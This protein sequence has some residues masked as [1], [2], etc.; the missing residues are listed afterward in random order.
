M[1]NYK[2]AVSKDGKKYNIVFKAENEALARERVH[3][4]WYSILSLQEIFGKKEIW[5]TFI[6]EWI[7][8]WEYKQG[9]IVWNDIFKSYVKLRKDLDYDVKYI[10]SEED[11]NLS[12][13]KIL[14]DLL[15]P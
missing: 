3:K 6:F 12:I 13:N 9:K 7:K 14:T 10:Y 4:E 8:L 11:N 5:N 2:I 1:A 15:F